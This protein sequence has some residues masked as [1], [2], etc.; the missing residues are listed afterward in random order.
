MNF[1]LYIKDSQAR[2]KDKLV[3]IE[4]KNSEKGLESEI[5]IRTINSEEY[6]ETYM[7]LS[8]D[9]NINAPNMVFS[10]KLTLFNPFFSN[11]ES[12]MLD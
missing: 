8:S 6:G 4:K 3:W 5:W 12:N 9:K 1:F 7:I 2:K 11:F 10:V